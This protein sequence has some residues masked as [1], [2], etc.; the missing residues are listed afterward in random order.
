MN[1]D[2]RCYFFKSRFEYNE[3]PCRQTY[4]S[5]LSIIKQS[6][7]VFID[8]FSGLEITATKK[9]PAGS[10]ICSWVTDQARVH[11]ANFDQSQTAWIETYKIVQT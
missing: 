5:L 2:I 9:N 10:K 8:S 1:T 7:T 11:F 6:L 3:R 4:K